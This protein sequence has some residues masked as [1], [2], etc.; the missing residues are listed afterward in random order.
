MIDWSKQRVV[1]TGAS[2]GIGEE[3][4]R[5]VARRGGVPILM[6]RS[7]GKLLNIASEIKEETG[8]APY[9]FE[10]DISNKEDIHDVFLNIKQTI[11]HVTV[12]VNNAGFGLFDSVQEASIEDIEA[13]FQVNVFGAISSTKSVLPSMIE[14][15]EGHIIFI[16]SQAGKLATPK[17]SGYSASKHAILGFANSLRMEVADENVNV[18][19]VNPGPVRTKFF[20]MADK[21]GEYQKNVERY[22]LDSEKVAIKTVD[23]IEKPKR[24]LNLPRWMSAASKLYQVY[25]TLVEAVA[26]KQFRKK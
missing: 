11:G 5:E 12:L 21:S 2:S 7:Y 4:A 25:P 26:G 15:N 9:V 1:I 8:V 10:V 14:K 13:M 18:S 23:L 17:S 16:A 20:D 19:V 3:V 24:E 22:M 6:A